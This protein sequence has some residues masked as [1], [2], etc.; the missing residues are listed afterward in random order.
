M[1]A[2]GQAAKR[3]F[4]KLRGQPFDGWR[5]LVTPEGVDLR[6]RVGAYAER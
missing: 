5:E 1:T 2:A 4:P 3:R 6:L